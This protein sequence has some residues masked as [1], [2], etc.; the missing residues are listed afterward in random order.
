LFGFIIGASAEFVVAKRKAYDSKDT[1]G[2]APSAHAQDFRPSSHALGT[3]IAA[4]F[5]RLQRIDLRSDQY[6]GKQLHPQHHHT[7]AR[8][9]KERHAKVD[10]MVH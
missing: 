5:L 4:R 3:W 2:G 1:S 10:T 7:T 6:Q 8:K 9:T